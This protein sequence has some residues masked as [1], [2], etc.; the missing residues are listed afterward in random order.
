MKHKSITVTIE[1]R[2]DLFEDGV[3]NLV[4]ECRG[5]IDD[6]LKKVLSAVS[7]E[8]LAEQLWQGSIEPGSI[9]QALL[10]L[11][12]LQ[13]FLA[14]LSAELGS[15]T[16]GVFERPVQL[17]MDAAQQG[18]LPKEQAVLLNE[19]LVWSRETVI[20]NKTLMDVC[21][22]VWN[23]AVGDCIWPVRKLKPGKLIW[24]LL[25]T[26]P[27]EEERRCLQELTRAIEGTRVNMQK[28]LFRA[29]SVQMAAQVWSLYDDLS[30][31]QTTGVLM[32]PETGYCA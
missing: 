7:S 30:Q 32:N 12:K 10:S 6:R 24:R 18:A 19:Q 8:V 22:L 21:H 11:D 5:I 17:Q 16:T 23:R 20:L 28:R 27:A 14:D 13:A 4:A 29:I 3:A 26:A 2:N 9:Q 31:D 25:E 1:T 15:L